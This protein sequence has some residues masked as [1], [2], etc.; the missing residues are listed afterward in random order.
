M[1]FNKKTPWPSALA[2]WNPSLCA[3]L[4]PRPLSHSLSHQLR[5]PVTFSGGFFAAVSPFLMLR[6]CGQHFLFVQVQK[7][8]PRAPGW[9]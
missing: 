6:A 7:A 4:L 5:L 2:L 9:D 3:P 1:G 8:R